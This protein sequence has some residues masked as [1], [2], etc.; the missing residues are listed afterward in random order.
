MY[1]DWH[2]K[3]IQ[4]CMNLRESHQFLV[5]TTLNLIPLPYFYLY[6]LVFI[7]IRLAIPYLTLKFNIFT[8]HSKK[9]FKFHSNID[10]LSSE[11]LI[12]FFYR[13]ILFENWITCQ[14]FLFVFLCFFVFF[15][16]RLA[17]HLLLSFFKSNCYKL[18]FFLFCD[19]LFACFGLLFNQLSFLLIS[20]I[21][22]W[23][24]VCDFLAFYFN[25]YLIAALNWIPIFESNRCTMSYM[26]CPTGTAYNN[27]IW[28]MYSF[29]SCFVEIFSL[30]FLKTETY[31]LCF[32]I[33][34]IS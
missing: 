13:Y 14:Y 9:I 18:N 19:C 5:P 2:Q 4:S 11:I 7:N 10:A 34:I 24:P 20:F 33:V 28:M 22:F 30:A 3:S 15:L 12:L 27:P 16:L 21:T 26:F 8:F 31:T 6:L 32:G 25:S 23:L 29:K 1:Q 17:V